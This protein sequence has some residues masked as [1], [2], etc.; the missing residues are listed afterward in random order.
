MK[1]INYKF[2][3]YI[4][5]DLPLQLLNIA[6][7]CNYCQAYFL[8]IMYLEMW[9]IHEKNLSKKYNYLIM[10][11]VEFQKIAQEVSLI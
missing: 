1:I 7:A 8:S 11:N 6:R 3:N 2:N 10:A 9:A 5:R 4:L